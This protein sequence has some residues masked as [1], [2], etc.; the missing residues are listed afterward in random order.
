MPRHGETRLQADGRSSVNVDITYVGTPR[1]TGEAAISASVPM[2]SKL[3]Y[4]LWAMRMEVILEAYGL[5]G[6]IEDENMSRKLDRRAVAVIYSV[7]PKDVLAQLDNKVTT[8]ETWESLC[9]MN[10]GVERVKKAKIQTLKCEFDNK[11][12]EQGAS[13][14]TT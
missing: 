5:L 9:T 4:P 11:A 12:Q 10:V 8:K 1:V 6:A 14:W 7:V 3:N 13:S 2:L